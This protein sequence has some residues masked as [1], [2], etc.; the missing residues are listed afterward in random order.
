MTIELYYYNIETEVL[1]ER[2]VCLL[3]WRV[4]RTKAELALM[5]AGKTW[6]QVAAETKTSPATIYY[7]L[8][9]K[10][11]TSTKTIGKLAKALGVSAA[12]IAE[13]IDD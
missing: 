12:D 13:S 2:G 6:A 3:A 4:V 7:A 5:N 9:G 1:D 8:S 11:K 10:R